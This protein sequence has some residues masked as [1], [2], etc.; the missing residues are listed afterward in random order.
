MRHEADREAE[1]LLDLGLVLVLADLVRRDVVEHGRGVGGGLERA[2]GARDAR[3]RVDDHARLRDRAGDR[4]EREQRRGRVATGVGDQRPDRRRELRQRVAPGVVPARVLE[5]VPLGVGVGGEP[6]RAGEVD[7]DGVR[8]W[9]E[10]GGGLV[11]EAAEDELRAG[12]ERLAVRDERRQRA[13]AVAAEPGVERRD[14]PARERLRPDGDELQLRMRK[15]AV[16]RLLPG[17]SRSADDCRANHVGYYAATSHLCNSIPI[18]NRSRSAFE[19]DRLVRWLLVVIV[20]AGLARA[21]RTLEAL[22]A[23]IAGS[24]PGACGWS[25]SRRSA[26]DQRSELNAARSSDENSSGSSQAAKWPPLSTSLK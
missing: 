6:V 14:R 5:P 11:V 3:L 16:E 12:L 25:R 26:D 23:I 8:G 4:A 17:E 9:L 18:P 24:A 19:H 2:A 21:R 7:D 10:L 1:E 15:H 22:P 13:V 20:L